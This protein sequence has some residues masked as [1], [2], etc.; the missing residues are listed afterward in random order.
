MLNNKGGKARGRAEKPS[1]GGTSEGDGQNRNDGG[2]RTTGKTRTGEM[3]VATVPETEAKN[4]AHTGRHG[5]ASRSERGA[6]GG[7]KPADWEI[8]QRAREAGDSIGIKT[9]GSRAKTHCANRNLLRQEEETQRQKESTAT[10][11]S[12]QQGS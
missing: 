12:A 10:S 9:G 2:G 11:E 7:V 4:G 5:R 1:T 6:E 8:R 3:R